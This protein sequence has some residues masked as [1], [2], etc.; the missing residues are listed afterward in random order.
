MDRKQREQQQQ[1][2]E[3]I[4]GIVYDENGKKVESGRIYAEKV[5]PGGYWVVMNGKNLGEECNACLDQDD[6]VHNI[7]TMHQ[8]MMKTVDKNFRE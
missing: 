7:V 6:N 2:H 3:Q 5:C 8:C 4:E 1:E